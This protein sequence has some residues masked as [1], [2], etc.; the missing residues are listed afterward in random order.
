M[1]SSPQVYW[2]GTKCF[3]SIKVFYEK[4]LVFVPA[5]YNILMQTIYVM[6]LF[7]L[8]PLPAAMPNEFSLLLCLLSS[9]SIS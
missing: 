9:K 1:V 8:S 4:N 2:G 6:F 3:L 5:K 7:H